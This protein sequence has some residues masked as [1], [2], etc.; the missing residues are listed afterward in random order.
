MRVFL[1]KSA[2]E[3]VGVNA[4]TV[5]ISTYIVSLPFHFEVPETAC[6]GSY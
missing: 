1:D 3:A 6:V 2:A 4:N 5:S